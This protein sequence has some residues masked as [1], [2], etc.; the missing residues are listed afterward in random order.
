M[1]ETKY[2]YTISTQT[3]AGKVGDK[4]I[5]EVT[6]SAIVIAFDHYDVVGDTL[7]VW[8]KDALSAGDQTLLTSIVAAHA[9]EDEDAGVR[10]DGVQRVQLTPQTKV[11]T[12]LVVHGGRFLAELS[13]DGNPHVTDHH[14]TFAEERALQGA[15]AEVADHDPEDTIDLLITH[16]GPTPPAGTVLGQFGETLPV[17]P[18]GRMP[19]VV[20]EGTTEIPAGIQVT[21]R[22]TTKKQTGNQPAVYAYLR[23]HR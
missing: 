15:F 19:D 17:P 6:T 5:G 8:F 1:A 10:N 9:G 3:A 16:P 11:G 7:D 23:T 21:L 18:S 20:S 13:P 2:T 12:V 22:Y 14:V 4:L